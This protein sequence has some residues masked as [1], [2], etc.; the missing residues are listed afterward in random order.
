MGFIEFAENGA[1]GGFWE[2]Y[3]IFIPVVIFL[4]ISIVMKRKRGAKTNLEV[5]IGLLSD[6]KHNL[7]ITDTL[8]STWKTF[9]KFKTGNWQRNGE[10]I[11]FLDVELQD[12]IIDAFEMAEEYNERIVSAKKNKSTSYLMG[13]QTD[14]LADALNQAREGLEVW[15]RENFQTE[16][17]KG[18]K[19][20]LFG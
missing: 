1:S 8:S 17:F 3:G 4:I 12:H 7:K 9:K 14:K 11:E 13:I 16:M 5:A 6:I 19:R 18:R 20:G 15:V 10:K 2:T